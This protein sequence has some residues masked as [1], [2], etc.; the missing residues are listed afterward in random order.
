[1]QFGILQPLPSHSEGSKVCH[2]PRVLYNLAA[3]SG[4]SNPP[5]QQG[6][7]DRQNSDNFNTMHTKGAVKIFILSKDIKYS[8]YV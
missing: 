4:V 7:I 2:A 1:M 8:A 3:T 5:R 6:I